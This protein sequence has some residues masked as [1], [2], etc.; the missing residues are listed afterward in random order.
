MCNLFLIVN[1]AQRSGQVTAN[2][3]NI[4]KFLITHVEKNH[5]ISAQ[6]ISFSVVGL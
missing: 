1:Y 2:V 5:T 6:E 4:I 3:Y